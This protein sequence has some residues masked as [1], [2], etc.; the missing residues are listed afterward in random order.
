MRRSS[1]TRETAFVFWKTLPFSA[2]SIALAIP[3]ALFLAIPIALFLAISI[4][5]LLAI[6]IAL[7]ISIARLSD[8][9]RS[10]FSDIHRSLSFS[11]EAVY[12]IG[13]VLC[14]F[15]YFLL[16]FDFEREWRLFLCY[17]CVYSMIFI[18]AQP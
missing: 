4:A 3:I 16:F 14:Y 13:N 9:Y 6:F 7:A 10:I 11:I 5:R 12:V 2:I 17:F 15:S 1:A 18:L 8:S